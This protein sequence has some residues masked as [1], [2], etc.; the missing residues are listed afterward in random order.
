MSCLGIKPYEEQGYWR[1]VGTLDAYWQAHMDMVD[2]T[3]LLELRNDE[4]PIL[5]DTFDGPTGS[6]A[7]AT[8][9]DSL[10]GQGSLVND[11]KIR[12]SVIGRN[13]QIEDRAEVEE[14]VILD[15]GRI[16]SKARLRRVIADR[17]NIIPD[18]TEIGLT[19]DEDRTRDQTTKSGLVILPRGRSDGKGSF[20]APSC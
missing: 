10:V 18:A 8:I 1:D 3:P 9:K 7:R 13:V 6:F 20:T 2:A 4:W 11:A 12:R 17:Y 16:G 14:C 15:G 19:V 5:T